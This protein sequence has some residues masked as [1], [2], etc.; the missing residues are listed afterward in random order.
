MDT[1][2]VSIN[3][4]LAPLRP[5]TLHHCHAILSMR[6]EAQSS[7]W[8]R[9]TYLCGACID[10]RCSA[11][12]NSTRTCK[13]AVSW[14]LYWS[15]TNMNMATSD[16]ASSYAAIVAKSHKKKIIYCAAN[17]RNCNCKPGAH[18]CCLRQNHFNGLLIAGGTI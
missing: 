4:S 18:S 6:P 8:P 3:G 15:Q 12:L 10:S 7:R 2:T 17:N 5:L 1:N 14:Q 9:L 16:S 13:C 11:T